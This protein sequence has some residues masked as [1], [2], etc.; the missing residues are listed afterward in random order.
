MAQTYCD[1]EGEWLIISQC[2]ISPNTL[3]THCILYSSLVYLDDNHRV[4]ISDG[5][6]YNFLYIVT[7]FIAH[8]DYE[9][10]NVKI[11]V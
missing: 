8:N 6:N 5:Y 10:V 11:N 4:T 2:W 3:L 1:H 9:A 7:Q